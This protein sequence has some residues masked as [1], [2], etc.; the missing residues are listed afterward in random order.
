M[1][2]IGRDSIICYVGSSIGR[3]V[4]QTVGWTVGWLVGWLVSRSVTH[5]FFRRFSGSFRLTA[6]AQSH[7]TDS[8]VYTALFSRTKHLYKMVRP[9]LH[10]CT[11]GRKYKKQ[12][13]RV[14]GYP[15]HC[16][17]VRSHRSLFR[18]LRAACFVR[19]ASAALIWSLAPLLRCSV[20]LSVGPL[21]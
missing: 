15:L 11:E 10:L 3:L 17:L 18:S 1:F 20:A 21:R 14:L 9:S 13:H 8:A 7:A 16:S 4:G 12:T 19:F 2:L 5:L 6:P